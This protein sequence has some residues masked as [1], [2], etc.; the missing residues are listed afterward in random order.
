MTSSEK[1][2]QLNQENKNNRIHQKHV[3]KNGK[4]LDVPE[5]FDEDEFRNGINDPENSLSSIVDCKFHH[6][7][8][9]DNELGAGGAT[10]LVE[11]LIIISMLLANISILL[12][13]SGH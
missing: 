1:D 10:P 3:D 9:M 11:M 12:A 7:K 6:I 4:A 5:R 13:T 8:S 2:A